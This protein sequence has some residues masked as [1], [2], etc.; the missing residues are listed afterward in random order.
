MPLAFNW[1]L[2]LGQ[3]MNA[4]AVIGGG[5]MA[6][7]AIRS[8]VRSLREGQNDQKERLQGVEAEVKKLGEVVTSNARIEERVAA[9]GL[10]VTAIE[11]KA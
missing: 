8:D 6:L 1:N 9:L 4:L 2:D 10:R 11:A 5:I 7:S 3:I